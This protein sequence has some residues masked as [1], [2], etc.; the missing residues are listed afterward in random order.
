MREIVL[1]TETTGL[2]PA[3]GDR[4]VE[5]GAIELWNHL[6]TGKTF[7]KYLNPER[8]MP[9]EAQAVHGLTEE[10]L[11]DKPVFAQI[12]DDFLEFI[13]DSNLKSVT[14][15]LKNF[16]DKVSYK[17]GK[18]QLIKNYGIGAQIIKS[19]HIR[20]MILVT[21]SRKKVVGLDGYGIRITKQEII[22]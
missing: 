10:F 7:H 18:D 15:T 3:T 22:K 14:Q 19:L 13:K 1:D 16:K 6:P 4:I 5:I 12:A 20:D 11:K 21:R 2:D 9:E 17:K 8:N